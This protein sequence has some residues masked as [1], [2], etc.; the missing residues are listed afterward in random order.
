[1]ITFES[2]TKVYP[3]G[4]KAVD[5]F[6]LQIECGETLVMVGS[7]GSGKTTLLRMVN[8]M[9]EPDSGRVL[10]NNE[11]IRT[12]NPVLLRRRIG[13]V[14]QNPGLM[15]HQS[16][17]ANAAITQR[18][19]GASRSAANAKAAEY[20]DLVNIDRSLWD[21]YPSQLSGGQAQRVAVARALAGE[22][23]ILLMDEPFGAVDPIV[24]RELQEQLMAVQAHLHKTILFVTHDIEE[25]FLLGTHVVILREGGQIAQHGTP[26]DISAHPQND[27]V[28][29]FIGDHHSE[30]KLSVSREGGRNI[31]YDEGGRPLG[32]IEP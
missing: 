11:D 15:P 28:R 13:Y 32:V 9:E 1:M 19:Q 17:L 12:V 16:V 20:L 24:R 3:S 30:R 4:S 8:R 31:V 29:A 25:A 23:K 14:P 18:L 27:F 6:S 7:S 10:I 22:S 2:I 21:R 5:D 26:Q